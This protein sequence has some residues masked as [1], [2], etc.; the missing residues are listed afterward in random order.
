[1]FSF[2]GGASIG[3]GL[4]VDNLLAKGGPLFNR[5]IQASTDIVIDVKNKPRDAS[6]TE[7][8]GNFQ[9]TPWPRAKNTDSTKALC[10]R[11]GRR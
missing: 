1:M 2:L 11:S 8:V 6:R 9:S 10:Q 3:S 4:T 7:R 5:R